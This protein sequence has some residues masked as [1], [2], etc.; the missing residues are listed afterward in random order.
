MEGRA[1]DDRIEKIDPR[2]LTTLRDH[3]HKTLR[4]AIRQA[5]ANAQPVPE[6]DVPD[7]REAA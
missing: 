1:G 5:F 6:A 2:F 3:V 7:L 4:A